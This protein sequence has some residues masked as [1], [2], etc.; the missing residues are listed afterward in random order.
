MGSLAQPDFRPRRNAA[1][2]RDAAAAA[3]GAISAGTACAVAAISSA[4]GTCAFTT[5]AATFARADAYTYADADADA[6]ASAAAA[7]NASA[8][9]GYCAAEAGYAPE[10]RLPLG[11]HRG[12]Q[13]RTRRYSHVA[14]LLWVVRYARGVTQCGCWC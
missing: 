11:V 13:S 10:Q 2:R 5:G 7:A 14:F 12:C 8:A 4:A 9:G 3:V 6:A 1:T